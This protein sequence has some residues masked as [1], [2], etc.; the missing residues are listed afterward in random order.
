MS[1]KSLITDPLFTVLSRTFTIRELVRLKAVNKTFATLVS[2][3]IQLTA[4]ARCEDD[5]KDW[6]FPLL[7]DTIISKSASL[8]SPWIQSWTWSGVHHDS[9]GWIHNLP[10]LMHL[11][12]DKI[13]FNH[14]KFN[15]LLANAGGLLL[16]I[17]KYEILEPMQRLAWMLKDKRATP[18]LLVSNPLTKEW[19][20]LPTANCQDVRGV[21]WKYGK[22]RAYMVVDEKAN[23]YK[24][25]LYLKGI[26]SV[27]KSTSNC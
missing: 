27:Y 9:S 5:K 22:G 18:P 10:S 20:V 16:F 23:S 19:R 3:N 13:D 12:S 11:P 1:T 7:L 8:Q 2:N 15:C 25:I 4:K 24:V 26:L 6:Y 17:Q 14:M 21:S